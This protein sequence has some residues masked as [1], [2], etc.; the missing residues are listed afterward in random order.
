MIQTTSAQAGAYQITPWWESL[1]RYFEQSIQKLGVTL[2]DIVQIVAFL[3]IG[4]FIGFLL[5]KYLRYFF[6]LTI[7]MIVFFIVFDRFGIILVNWSHVQQLTGIDPQS[8]IQQCG[9]RMLFLVTENVI[10]TISGLIGFI[11][12]YRVG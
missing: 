10:L 11:I 3:G 5:K 6:I 2:Q 4:F 8:T 7:T 1:E 9:E 12:G